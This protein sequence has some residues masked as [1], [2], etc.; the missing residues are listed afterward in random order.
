VLHRALRPGGRLHLLHGRGPT[1][2]D[3]ITA[4]LA[5]RVAGHGFVDVVV[6]DGPDGCGV[7]ART[8]PSGHCCAVP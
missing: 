3:R 8:Q 7:T 6:H 1:P 5:A 2:A 4:T